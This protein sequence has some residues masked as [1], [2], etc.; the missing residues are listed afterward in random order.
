M[1]LVL[2]TI[3]GAQGSVDSLNPRMGMISDILICSIVITRILLAGNGV[4]IMDP[5][6]G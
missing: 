3:L 6:T 2:I 5:G 4:G 1:I